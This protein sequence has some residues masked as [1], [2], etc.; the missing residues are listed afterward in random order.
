MC[1]ADAA[2]FF[3]VD[4][5]T[6]ELLRRDVKVVSNGTFSIA[7]SAVVTEMQVGCF[8]LAKMCEITCELLKRPK[9]PCIRWGS[10]SP[11]GM[12]NFEGERGVPL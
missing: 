4:L 5:T 6:L 1:D 10:G 2:V 11:T 7:V 3:C 9:E 12:G 8:S